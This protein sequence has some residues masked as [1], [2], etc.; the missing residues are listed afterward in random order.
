MVFWVMRPFSLVCGYKLSENIVYI[1]ASTL[2]MEA[3]CLFET[4]VTTYQSTQFYNGEN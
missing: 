3:V 4:S 2:K 1:L